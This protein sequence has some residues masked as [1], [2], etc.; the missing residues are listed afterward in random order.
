[1]TRAMHSYLLNNLSGGL[2][3]VK[4]D[5]I[6][7]YSGFYRS[8][9]KSPSREVTI[10]ARLVSKDIRSTTAKN[11]RMVEKET[12]GLTWAAPDLKIKEELA[13]REAVCEEVDRW[14][15]PYLGKLL[16]ER[17]TLVYQGKEDSNQVIELQELI[18][19]LCGSL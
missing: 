12:G 14:R 2:V 3:P 16:E 8:L 9:L 7:R 1:M 11:L 4:R 18:D 19:S 10:L 6:A 5:I 13:K 15:I 17:D